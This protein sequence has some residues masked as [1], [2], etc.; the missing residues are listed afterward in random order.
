MHEFVLSARNLKRYG[1]RAT[2]VVKRLLDYGLHAPTVYFPL[3]VEEALMIEPVETESREELDRFADA[4]EKIA[5]EA[6]KHPDMLHEAP[7][8]T[9]VR[10][11]DEAA[12]ARSPDLCFRGEEG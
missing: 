3:I 7:V 4:L 12:A 9:P 11:L 1:V 2:D 10:R 5:G 6:E 8:T